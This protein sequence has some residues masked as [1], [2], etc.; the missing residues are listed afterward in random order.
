[1]PLN[2]REWSTIPM[3]PTPTINY[4]RRLIIVSCVS[5]Q[6]DPATTTTTGAGATATATTSTT[7][8]ASAVTSSSTMTSAT[9]VAVASGAS[10]SAR[11]QQEQPRGGTLDALLT[12]TYCRN[13]MYLSRQLAQLHPELTMPM[14]SGKLL[15][16]VWGGSKSEETE[17]L[18]ILR[19]FIRERRWLCGIESRKG[20][21]GEIR[22]QW[23]SF[24]GNFGIS[25]FSG[26]FVK[27]I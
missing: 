3:H 23:K 8:V 19:L 4:H 22:Y 5:G 21:F 18:Y 1:M 7:T 20:S 11:L 25:E 14:F 27:F 16:E 6:D 12:T 10:Q 13:Q 17:G 9:A 15:S 24:E 26:T 2:Q